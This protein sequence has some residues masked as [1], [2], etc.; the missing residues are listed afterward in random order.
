MSRVGKPDDLLKMLP[1][2]D[3]VAVCVPLTAETEHLF[4]SKAFADRLK[5]AAGAAERG[6]GEPILSS[7]TIDDARKRA[8][9]D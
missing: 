8:P 4:D 6:A 2:A 3:V 1:E 7:V 9:T 5:D